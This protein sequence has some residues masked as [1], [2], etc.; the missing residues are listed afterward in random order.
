[1]FCAMILH[2]AIINK[3]QPCFSATS[4][5]CVLKDA[6]VDDILVRL[7]THE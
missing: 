1:M 7:N 2:Y 6:K 4:S 3:E 5:Y